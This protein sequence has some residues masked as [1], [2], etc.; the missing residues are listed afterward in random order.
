MPADEKT[1]PVENTF[2]VLYGSEMLA[3]FM[4]RFIDEFYTLSNF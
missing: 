4:N 2:F 1:I 3:C